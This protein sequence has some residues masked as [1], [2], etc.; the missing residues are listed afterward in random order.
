MATPVDTSQPPNFRTIDMNAEVRKVLGKKYNEPELAYEF[1]G[2]RKFYLRTE[3][4]AIYE[5]SPDF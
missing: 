1:S 4:A 5:T 3:D 2:G